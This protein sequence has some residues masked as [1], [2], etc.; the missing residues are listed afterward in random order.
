MKRILIT[1]TLALSIALTTRAQVMPSPDAVSMIKGINTPVNLYTGVASIGVP[2]YSVQANNGAHVPVSLSYHTGGVKVKDIAGVAG[3]GWHL[4]AGGSIT[5]IVRDYPDE[6]TN[7]DTTINHGTVNNR[8]TIDSEKDIFY[9]SFPGGSGKFVFSGSPYGNAVIN[10]PYEEIATFSTQDIKVQFYYAYDSINYWNIID[11]FGNKYTFGIDAN[12]RETT[13]SNGRIKPASYNSDNEQKF[14]STW[15][16]TKIEYANQPSSKAI[17]FSYIHYSE[18][19]ET[20]ETHLA[21]LNDPSGSYTFHTDPAINTEYQSEID[22]SY[23]TTITFPKGTVSFNYDNPRTDLTNGRRL[24]KIEVKEP[25]ASSAVTVIDFHHSYFNAADSYYQGNKQGTCTDEECYRLKLDSVSLDGFTHRTFD[26]ANDKNFSSSTYGN[27]DF[28]ELPRRDSYYYDNWGYYC[29]GTHQG[30]TY[31][32]YPEKS[33]SPTLGGIDRSSDDA[34]QAN[35]LVEVGYPTGGYTKYEYGHNVKNGGVRIETMKSYDENDNVVN[36]ILYTY[37]QADENDHPE[38][39]YIVK[40]G[41]DNN[42]HEVAWHVHSQAP[43]LIFDLNGSTQGYKKVKVK[44]NNTGIENTHYFIDADSFAVTPSNKYLYE[45]DNV[46]AENSGIVPGSST[47]DFR[48][49]FTSNHLEDYYRGLEY[50]VETR[51]K[52]NVLMSVTETEYAQSA[53]EHTIS[54]RSIDYYSEDT[55]GAEQEYNFTIS[56]YDIET[57]YLR[58]DERTTRT[59]NNSGTLASEVNTSYLYNSNYGSLPATIVIQRTDLTG[60]DVQDT[61]QTIRYPFTSGISKV[62]SQTVLDD[63]VDDNIVA[64]PIQTINEIKRDGEAFYRARGSVV[65]TFRVQDGMFQ[66]YQT[67]E[68]NVDEPTNTWG[69]SD[70]REVNTQSYNADG[71]LESSIGLGDVETEYFYSSLGYL[72]SVR[73]DPGSSLPTRT[74]KY[75]YEPLVGIKTVTDPNNF[76]TTYEYDSRKRLHLIRDEDGNIVKRYR[77]NYATESDSLSATISAT[78]HSDGAVANRNHTFSLNNIECP[79]GECKY[80]FDWGDGT[81]EPLSTSISM[82]HSYASANTYTITATIVNPEYE[83]PFTTTFNAVISNDPWVITI[84]EPSQIC[85]EDPGVTVHSF[86]ATSTGVS[87]VIPIEYTWDYKATSSSTW[88]NLATSSSS[89]SVDIPTSILTSTGNYDIRV[90]IVDEAN[91]DK[92]ETEGFEVEDCTPCTM[93]LSSYSHNFTSAGGSQNFTVTTN[94]SSWSASDNQLWISTSKS[95]STLTVSAQNYTGTG[96]RTGTVTVTGAENCSRTIS[97]T[98]DGID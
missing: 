63:M 48:A 26:Y 74:T 40:Y 31:I 30:T 38:I 78:Y 50:K 87:L 97:I 4:N 8:D 52:S 72:D 94:A 43:S 13:T 60:T 57:K 96:S 69:S 85:Q 68:L 36:D 79:Y 27:F 64:V 47:I 24:D 2:L 6:Q 33:T 82:T 25:G 80:A 20:S 70:F 23:L 14:I 62:H 41:V 88:I 29:G 84:N 32:N 5:R 75:T 11:T 56:E 90:R 1:I 15:H 7:F 18:I 73:V 35:I 81:S 10:E 28:Y 89:N 71:L 37:N 98:Q 76:T 54:N 19:T 83:E 66:P 61:R 58:L 42:G 67:F 44:N 53:I 46:T 49:P 16:L 86:S 51:D 55:E 3:L 9:Y 91:R 95:G 21:R 59:Y 39:V 93:T 34:N 17:S 12:S 45:I 65:T 77:Y 22:I 92:T